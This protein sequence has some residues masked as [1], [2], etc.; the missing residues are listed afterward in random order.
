MPGVRPLETDTRKRRVPV[1]LR[2][3]KR[4]HARNKVS[5]SAT[6]DAS[7]VPSLLR[8]RTCAERKGLCT[9]IVLDE[10]FRI[11]RLLKKPSSGAW[12]LGSS[13]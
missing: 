2:L 5:R 4:L 10:T 7:G 1:G 8:R 11:L 9:S 6:R 3:K 13:S 12:T